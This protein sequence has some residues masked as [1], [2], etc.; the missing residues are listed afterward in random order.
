VLARLR[1]KYMP[2]IT[3]EQLS[4]DFLLQRLDLNA[5]RRLRNV[6]TLGG[7]RKAQFLRHGDK[8]T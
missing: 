3:V 5:E 2:L 8:I 7:A 4:T 1:Q 6:Q